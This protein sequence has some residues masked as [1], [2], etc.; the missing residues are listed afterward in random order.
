MQ[1]GGPCSSTRLTLTGILERSV[2]DSTN[3]SVYSVRLLHWTPGCF[4]HIVLSRELE[5]VNLV[6]P[7]C[8]S[9]Q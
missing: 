3:P 6:R 8:G 4:D 9:N 7:D 5:N 2:A 1:I